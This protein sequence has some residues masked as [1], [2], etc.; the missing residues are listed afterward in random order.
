MA[1]EIPETSPLL[2]PSDLPGGLPDLSETGPEELDRLLR[3]GM[4]AQRDAWERIAA[5]PAPADFATVIE[6]LE[7][8]AAQFARVTG[9]FHTFISAMGTEEVLELHRRWAGPPGRA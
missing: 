6:P 3:S 7:T 1:P 5:D 2:R 9:I 8:A 4:A